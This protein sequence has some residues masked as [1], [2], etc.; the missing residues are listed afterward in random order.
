MKYVALL[1]FAALVTTWWPKVEASDAP[2]LWQLRRSNT[3]RIMV[4]R[5]TGCHYLVS[6]GAYAGAL[7][8]RL[9][10]MGSPMCPGPFK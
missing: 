5:E 1:L 2:E 9:N 8:P 10:R 7:I 3:V 6:D 4:D